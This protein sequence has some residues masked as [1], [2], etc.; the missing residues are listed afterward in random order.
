MLPVVVHKIPDPAPVKIL[1]GM[2]F[3][4]KAKLIVDGKNEMFSLEDP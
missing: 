1:L 2:S 3:I 4:E